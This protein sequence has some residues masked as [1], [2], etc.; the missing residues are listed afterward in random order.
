MFHGNK[1]VESLSPATEAE[2]DKG[3]AGKKAARRRQKARSTARDLLW[4]EN[5]LESGICILGGGKY[6]L[7]LRLSDINYQMA[8]E[9]RQREL[10]EKYARFFNGFSTGEQ[11]QI[12]IVNRRVEKEMLLAKVLLPAPRHADAVADLR[13]DQNRIVRGKIGGTE[14]SI[15][16]EKYLTLTVEATSLEHATAAL[17]RLSETVIAQMF[18]LLEC[19][20]HR[21]SGA[22]RTVL[23]RELTRGCY[24]DG[25]DYRGLTP[26]G[27]GTKDELAPMSVD[28]TN[29]KKI[30]LEGDSEDL[31]YETLVMRNYPSWMA[32]TLFKKLSEIYTDLVISFHINPIDKAES[33]ELVMRRKAMLDMEKQEKR[34]KLRKADMDPDNDLP[35]T[36]VRAL[37]EVTD[38]LDDIE[39]SDQRLFTTTLVVMV[40]AAS[41]EELQKRVKDIRAVAKAE[42]CDLASLRFFQVQAFNT[43]LPLGE[44]WVPVHRTMTTAATAVMVPFTSQEI[45]DDDG[46]FYGLNTA[47]QNPIIADR[48]RLR[49]GNGLVLGTSGAGKGMFVKAEMSQVL[50]ARPGD[51]VIIIDPEHEYRALADRFDASVIEVHAGSTQV[52]NPF[53]IV[54]DT[55]EGDPVRL[56]AEALLGMLRV[57]LGGARGLEAAQESIL[58][59]SITTLYGRYLQDPSHQVMPTLR[60]LHQELL[61]QPEPEAKGL[62]TSLELYAL[63]TFSGFAQETNVD[64]AN[65][66]L[67]YDISKLGDHMKTF[68]MMVVLDSVW[69]RV[70]LNRQ[71][72]VRTWLYVDEFHL[73]LTNQYALRQFL[74]IFKRARKYGLFPTGI[75]QN[76]QEVLD[77]PEARLMLGNCDCLFLLGQQKN[78]A[79]ELAAML[80]LSDEQ[81]RSFTS[82]EAGFGLVRFGA[83][84]LSFNGRRPQEGPL[85]ELFNTTFEDERA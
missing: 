56:K 2:N 67:Y 18:S 65:R 8:T 23:L 49:N 34:R 15:V 1:R 78:D 9:D 64:V 60:T 13:D 11:L 74:S 42:S 75:T 4:Y 16:S 53:D 54:M 30:V 47:T 79:D 51:D 21:V 12:T 68:G 37:E 76:V 39:Q 27:A 3:R 63:G 24:S 32:D 22:E 48:R 71:R 45:L 57:L 72:G 83:T 14:Y 50:L 29:P 17:N 58:D 84:T 62:A 41:D 46:L 38:L 59:R 26:S 82:V 70:Q 20:A 25:F 36:L 6:S 52:I 33:H 19:Q 35:H 7:T 69:N 5:L 44:T 40:R 31:H 43:A 80:A 73:M 10:L 85:Y 55:S 28:L 81:I 61:S 77:V 66:F